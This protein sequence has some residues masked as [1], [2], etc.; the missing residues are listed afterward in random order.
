MNI[1][2]I[3]R[4]ELLY[5]LTRVLANMGHVI[6]IIVTA[7]EAPEY[8]KTAKDFEELA[9]ELNC[10]YLYTSNINSLNSI[11]TVKSVGSIDL[12]IS[13]NHINIISKDIISLFSIGILNAHGGDLPRY[14][15][16]ACQA[17]AI[18]NGESSFGLCVHKMV[19]NE[20]DAGD[21]IVREYYALD[22]NS[23]VAGAYAWM[24]E[25]VPEMMIKAMELL[26]EHPDYYLA[27]QS[28]DPKD[29]LR[30]YPRVASDGKIS[31]ERSAVDILRLINASSEPFSGAFCMLDDEVIKI[32][33]A[34]LYEDDEV[35]CAVPGQV[36][37]VNQ[38]DGSIIVIT[39]VGKLRITEVEYKGVRT[40]MPRQIIK[41][42]RKR[43]K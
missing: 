10:A 5:D 7:K 41:S 27:K 39:G 16:N 18:I 11:E 40:A 4:T 6:K 8:L 12:G 19:G 17:W 33:R 34:F 29:G 2:I 21:I 43:L 32:W 30:C 14:R 37:N 26:S 28:S 22:I 13:F 24:Y 35:Y 36:A 23:R 15:G 20:L 9:A 38:P 3:G 31:W 42:I 25:R 1:A